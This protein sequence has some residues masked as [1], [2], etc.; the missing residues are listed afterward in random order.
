MAGAPHGWGSRDGFLALSHE[1]QQREQSRTRRGSA[2]SIF[3]LAS[4]VT[5]SSDGDLDEDGEEREEEREQGGERGDPRLAR[6]PPHLD[7]RLESLQGT[8]SVLA[9]RPRQRRSEDFVGDTALQVVVSEEEGE[10]EES[11]EGSFGDVNQGHASS[12]MTLPPSLTSW[13]FLFC[14]FPF[15]LLSSLPTF[16]H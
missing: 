9:D 3:S 12:R 14:R 1:F 7:G 15:S 13:T 2:S 11:S 8:D 5:T 4:T 10:E 6:A 16:F